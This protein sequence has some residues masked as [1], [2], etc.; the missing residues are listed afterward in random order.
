[1]KHG[2]DTRQP[3]TFYHLQIKMKKIQ[4]EEERQAVIDY[5]NRILLAKLTNVLRSD[6]Q[7]DNW[8][9][10][11][12]PKSLNGPFMEREQAK[13]AQENYH[14]QRRL[15]NVSGVYDADKWEDEYLMHEYYLSQK[16]QEVKS[17]EIDTRGFD[18]MKIST[19]GNDD[20]EEKLE[21]EQTDSIKPSPEKRMLKKQ[22]TR[23]PTLGNLRK[24]EQERK[25]KQAFSKPKEYNESEDSTKLFKATKGLA[26]T[27]KILI[28]TLA[29][30]TYIQRQQTKTKFQ[31]QYKLDLE[32]ELRL[33]LG[34]T[35]EH[36]LDALLKQRQTYDALCLNHAL[37]A[38][39]LIKDA[40]K[41]EFDRSLEDD[42]RASLSGDSRKMMLALVKGARRE[43]GSVDEDEVKSDVDALIDA[44][45][46]RWN[47][48][49]TMLNLLE[50]KSFD[51]IST[52]LQKYTEKSGDNL[53][54]ELRKVL[55]G[56]MKDM[57]LS[58]VKC[59][60]NCVVY[61]AEVLHNSLKKGD[62]E[63]ILRILST[64]VEIDLV[65]IRRAYKHRY[66]VLLEDDVAR[67]CTGH[68]RNLLVHMIS[69]H[70]PSVISKPESQVQSSK[71]PKLPPP[72]RVKPLQRP[73][74]KKTDRITSSNPL[75]QTS[76]TKS[77]RRVSDKK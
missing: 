8:N 51:H 23:L 59:L 4:A 69:I 30:R 46:S 5:E 36:I 54:H 35:Y 26:Q 28:E 73:T 50:N 66:G 71:I 27:K 3:K 62:N 6:G 44:G 43:T 68:Y 39:S 19:K 17:Y 45:E 53:D 13:I 40:Y 67:K 49:G 32:T 1:M 33:K 22:A 76:P 16:S 58:L 14:M 63:T 38:I 55:A 7:L 25:K 29:R 57:M 34:E 65:L 75:V 74:Q 11:Y 70:A 9:W 42:I 60:D 56:D 77:P 47:M 15:N 24:K 10:D 2:L 18:E 21:D 41:T 12:E 31:E 20:D 48:E 52:I 64:R 72:P 61:L 37:L